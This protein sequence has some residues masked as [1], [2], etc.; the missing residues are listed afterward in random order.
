MAQDFY[1][2]IDKIQPSQLYISSL[3][4]KNILKWFDPHDYTSYAPIPIKL[5]NNKIIFTD[6][7]TRAY[8]AFLQGATQVKV[9]W[10]EDELDW[11]DYQI[12]VDWCK[13]A[14]IHTIK[15]LQS[16]ILK[17]EEYEVLW[18]QKCKEMII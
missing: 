10:D 9:Y 6:G 18:I 13:E 14:D 15:D 12:Y 16:R 7:H 17:P 3:K 5:L 4:L 11:D 8:A 2:S 1:L